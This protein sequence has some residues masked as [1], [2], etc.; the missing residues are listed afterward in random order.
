[1]GRN[2]VED[3]FSRCG[4]RPSWRAAQEELGLGHPDSTVEAGLSIC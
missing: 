4:T 2:E 1:M 3:G